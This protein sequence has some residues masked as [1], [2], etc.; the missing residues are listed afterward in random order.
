MKKNQ[1]KNKV[2]SCWTIIW[3]LAVIFISTWEY[4]IMAQ[5]NIPEKPILNITDSGFVQVEGGQLFYEISGEG[6]QLIF[7]HD[8]I[9][10]RE[11]YD[12][13]FG[14]FAEDYEVIRYDRRGYGRSSQPTELFSPIQDLLAV[15]DQL[16]V[17][18][19][20]LIGC[21]A[22]G[23]LAIDFTLAHPDKVI[24][25][26]L[27]G[28]VVSGYGYSEHCL[29][30][31]GYFDPASFKSYDD[32]RFY[33][34]HVDPYSIIKE[35]QQVRLYADRIIT[36]NL[37]NLQRTNFTLAK[38]P[39][40]PAMPNLNEI[41]VPVLL[42]IGE[43]DLPDLHAHAGVIEAGIENSRRYIMKNA[44]HLAHMEHPDEF[45]ALVKNFYSENSFFEYIA[46]N[47]ID[48]Y[49]ENMVMSGKI[50]SGNF[51]FD[52]N[53]MNQLGYQRLLSD[54]IDE[55]VGFF[56]LSAILNPTSFNAY[57]SFAEALLAKGDTANAIIIY[58]KSLELNPNNQNARDILSN[59]N[60][61]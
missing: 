60:I 48:A 7:I 2:N 10:H 3:I 44:G 47:S 31:G 14:V 39:E 51:P 13:Q 12:F 8:G 45:N 49:I 40:R 34:Y 17:N 55:A 54:K 43:S 33:L 38:D 30:R 4:N 53:R 19:A 25:L 11:T 23:G 29:T 16:G 15:F 28:A 20:H 35:N 32:Y 61:E 5:E 42:V 46:Q 22:G 9:L 50:D 57:D 56:R 1:I 18:Q 6:E 27:V 26:V 41:K 21:S 24:S 52:E 36:A 58:R 37:H 59:L